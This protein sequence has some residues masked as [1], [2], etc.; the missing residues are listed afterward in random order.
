MPAAQGGLEC[1]SGWL[2]GVQ[3]LGVFFQGGS[4]SW[5]QG[6][7]R[8]STQ[9]WPSILAWAVIVISWFWGLG[10]AKGPKLGWDTRVISCTL[11]PGVGWGPLG[12]VM[13]P[14]R[15]PPP[16]PGCWVCSSHPASQ[17][18]LVPARCPC[19]PPA[20]LLLGLG[21]K[22]QCP[23][24]WVTGWGCW[25]AWAAP[26]PIVAQRASSSCGVPTVPATQ[27]GLECCSGWLGG[28]RL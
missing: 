8:A 24:R 3:A 2:L 9:G 19:H 27:G 13:G 21:P 16:F 17:P 6:P 7:H 4:R 25:R 18:G 10:G 12:A 26:L 15:A 5:L 20:P 14:L 23:T 11:V 28:C 1:C 22:G